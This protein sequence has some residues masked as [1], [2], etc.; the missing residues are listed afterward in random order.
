M[1]KTTILKD[2]ESQVMFETNLD[3]VSGAPSIKIETI[4]EGISK[5]A[6]ILTYDEGK[7]GLKVELQL[8]HGL[9]IGQIWCK[10]KQLFW[11]APNPLRVYENLD[12]AL[13]RSKV[14][15]KPGVGIVRGVGGWLDSFSSGMITCGLDCCGAPGK[16]PVTGEYLPL[17]S[18]IGLLPAKNISVNLEQ[19]SSTKF[20]ICVQGDIFQEKDGK[21][22]YKLH[23]ELRFGPAF[24]SNKIIVKDSV[25]NIGSCLL[26]LDAL[27][28]IQVGGDA[29]KEGSIFSTPAIKVDP[30]DEDAASKPDTSKIMPGLGDK[31]YQPEKCWFHSF[32]E[33]GLIATLLRDPEM[34]FGVFTAH[35]QNELP[36][37][38]QW[39]QRGGW[40][41]EKDPDPAYSNIWY[42]N[43][44][45]PGFTRPNNRSTEREDGRLQYLTPGE[46]R[47]VELCIGALNSADQIMALETS[48]NERKQLAFDDAFNLIRA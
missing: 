31:E 42:V 10:G 18:R 32:P 14:H 22:A 25:E 37:F 24:G 38:T 36:Q 4:L 5:G 46:K 30:R 43:A 7:P 34:S 15:K 20:A 23:R 28:H 45:E 44:P 6:K 40:Q 47:S 41:F 21:P 2:A 29:L 33:L 19:E 13:M 48:I 39:Q 11:T 35:R 26:P 27:Y 3:S 8:S 17:H 16:D 12:E 1:Q 9:N